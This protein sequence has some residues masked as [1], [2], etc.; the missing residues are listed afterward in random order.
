LYVYK[1]KKKKNSSLSSLKYIT[2]NGFYACIACV[3]F[4]L[5]ILEKKDQ[6]Y[7][8]PSGRI[9]LWASTRERIYT[10]PNR[11]FPLLYL[12]LFEK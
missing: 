10:S 6:L 2:F 9:L 8:K 11:A 1:V 5:E 4:I 12:E 3:Y 7:P